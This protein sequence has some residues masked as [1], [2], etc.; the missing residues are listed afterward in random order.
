M[1]RDMGATH[2][3]YWHQSRYLERDY[4]TRGRVEALEWEARGHLFKIDLDAN[5]HTIDRWDRDHFGSFVMPC[6]TQLD[7]DEFAR[8]PNFDPFIGQPRYFNGSF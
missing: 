8:D 7:P 5:R 2:G 6:E 3:V 4:L 1:S